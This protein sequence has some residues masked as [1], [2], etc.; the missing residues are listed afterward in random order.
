MNGCLTNTLLVLLD[1]RHGST[2]DLLHR[3]SYVASVLKYNASDRYLVVL[4]C[5]TVHVPVILSVIDSVPGLVVRL[6]TGVY[7]VPPPPKPCWGRLA[8]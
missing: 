7:A 4:G 3:V 8:I 5:L 6:H 2:G 1:G